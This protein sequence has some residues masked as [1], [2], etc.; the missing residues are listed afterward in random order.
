LLVVL[1]LE[2]NEMGNDYNVMRISDLYCTSSSTKVGN[3]QSK[4]LTILDG[5]DEKVE[6][7]IYI[8]PIQS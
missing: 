6:N 3:N 7:E 5:G 2:I 1:V 8:Q 4:Y